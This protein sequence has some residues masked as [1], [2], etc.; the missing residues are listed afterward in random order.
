MVISSLSLS[1]APLVPLFFYYL[2]CMIRF[3]CVDFDD[4]KLKVDQIGRIKIQAKKICSMKCLALFS[5]LTW[6]IHFWFLLYTSLLVVWLLLSNS[7]CPASWWHLG[8]LV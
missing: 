7:A 5:E 8:T 2:I 3:V 4:I 6:T 1:R